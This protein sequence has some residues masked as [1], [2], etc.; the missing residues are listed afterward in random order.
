MSRTIKV[1]FWVEVEDV[2]A[3]KQPKAMIGTEERPFKGFHAITKEALMEK[4]AVDYKK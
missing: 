1:C 2:P 4:A 3:P